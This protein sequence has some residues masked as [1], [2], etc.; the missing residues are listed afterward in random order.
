MDYHTY[1]NIIYI[2]SL[3]EMQYSGKIE[4]I[5]FNIK[6]FDGICGPSKMSRS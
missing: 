3:L 1:Y 5:R 2:I 4:S 6:F